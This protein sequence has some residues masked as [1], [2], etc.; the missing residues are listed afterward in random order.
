M[1]KRDLTIL[2]NQFVGLEVP[3]EPWEL[4][5]EGESYTGLKPVRDPD[6]V[7]DD[8]NRVAQ[9]NGLELI[10]WNPTMAESDFEAFKNANTV[11]VYIDQGSDGKYRISDKFTLG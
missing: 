9:S 3:L 5:L 4:C 1:K 7:I 6:P 10:F 2:F 8:M 11:N